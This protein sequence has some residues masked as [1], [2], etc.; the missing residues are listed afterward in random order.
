M[1]TPISGWVQGGFMR[2]SQRVQGPF[3]RVQ[4]SGDSMFYEGSGDGTGGL[5]NINKGEEHCH[6]KHQR[7]EEEAGR[8]GK[9]K[10]KDG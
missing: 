9:G 3:E 6:G 5:Y 2:G 4:G 7:S 1:K 10:R 8:R